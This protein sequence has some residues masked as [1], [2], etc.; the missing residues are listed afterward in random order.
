ME[1]EEPMPY[2]CLG[3]Q[4]RE[5]RDFSMGSIEILTVML[6]PRGRTLRFFPWNDVWRVSKVVTGA[7][8]TEAAEQRA[9]RLW[10][11]RMFT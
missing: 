2:Y 7:A 4:V 3:D 11:T 5:M 1:E 6:S 10:M 9:S 8:K